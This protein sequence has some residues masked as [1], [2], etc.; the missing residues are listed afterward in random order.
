MGN[1]RDISSMRKKRGETRRTRLARA[2]I[3]WVTTKGQVAQEPVLMEDVN[4]SGVG[5]RIRFALPVDFALALEVH[6]QIFP[7]T[8]RHCNRDG[9]EYFVGIEFRSPV[10]GMSLAELRTA[11]PPRLTAPRALL[12]TA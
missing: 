11:L 8:V 5:L 9:H 6:D 1:S 2:K 10:N 3:V 4:R 12:P 7:A